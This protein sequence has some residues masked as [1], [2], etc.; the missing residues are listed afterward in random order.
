MIELPT[1]VLCLLHR[2][3]LSWIPPFEMLSPILLFQDPSR[4]A[5]PFSSPISELFS[6]LS[7]F[8]R[9][10]WESSFTGNIARGRPSNSYLFLI[11]VVFGEVQ[12]VVSFRRFEDG[13]NSWFP[14]QIT[15]FLIRG[16]G[17]R[18]PHDTWI[19]S[20]TSLVNLNSVSRFRAGC[21][22]VSRS[23][24][25]SHQTTTGI[26]LFSHNVEVFE[27]LHDHRPGS[28]FCRCP[29]LHFDF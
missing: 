17:C 18:T 1:V 14:I 3:L 27:A 12:I 2:A 16:M 28:R 26:R 15:V 13:E 23:G 24:A 4:D 9:L 8:R 19:R 20:A 6:N 10:S 29:V 11:L 22:S 25:G 21:S 7:L 5:L